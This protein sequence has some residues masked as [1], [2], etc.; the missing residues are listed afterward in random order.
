MVFQGYNWFL[1]VIAVVVSVLAL[2]I[3]VYVLVSYQHPEDR[4]QV[5]VTVQQS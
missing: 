2:G 5:S 3:A 1:I 4:N